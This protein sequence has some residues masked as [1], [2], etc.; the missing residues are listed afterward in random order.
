MNFFCGLVFDKIGEIFFFTR[1]FF[2]HQQQH[3]TELTRV[4]SI[5]FE[6]LKKNN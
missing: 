5:L 4:L 1:L 3:I 2:K 6:N